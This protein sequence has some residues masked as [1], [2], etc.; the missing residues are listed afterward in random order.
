[1]NDMVCMNK[2]EEKCVVDPKLGNFGTIQA[3]EIN[4]YNLWKVIAKRKMIIIAIFLLS[5]L[6]ATIYCFTAPPI[7]RLETYAKLYM[8]KDILTVKEFPTAKDVASIIGKVDLERK[9]IIFSNTSNEITDAKIDEIKGATD[10]FRI[11]IESHNR[12]NLPAALQELIGYVENTREIKNDHEKIISEID[13]KIK[14]VKEAVKK[15]DYQIKEIE[16][17]LFSSKLLPVGFNPVEINN[18]IVALKMEKYRLEQE[19]QNYKPIQLLEDPFVSK[20][21]VKPKKALI[22]IFAAICGLTLGIFIVLISEYYE[23]MRKKKQHE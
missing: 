7:Y 5:L 17:R 14:N 15:N 11:T 3:D 6:G 4:L 13:E 10:K 16:K 23:G 20:Y 21:P 12:E 19:R 9:A 2:E 22:I 8:P 1:M 18:N